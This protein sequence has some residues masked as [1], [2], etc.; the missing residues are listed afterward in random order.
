MPLQRE[1]TP[2]KQQQ[3]ISNDELIHPQQERGEAGPLFLD[4]HLGILCTVYRQLPGP[5]TR[6]A[7]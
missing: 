3:P 4:I 1:E 2:R 5:K 7:T 6:P